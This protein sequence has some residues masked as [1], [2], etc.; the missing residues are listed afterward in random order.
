[1]L[2]GIAVSPG[3][4]VVALLRRFQR[5]EP[6]Y[7][8]AAAVSEEIARFDAACGAAAQEM[9]AVIARVT[10]QLG[11]DEAAIFHGHR[12]LLRDPA[13]VGKVKSSILHKKVDARSALHDLLDEYTSLFEKIEDEY[14]K[15]RMADIRDVV[16]H[17]D[18][19]SVDEKPK[20]LHGDEAII[21]VAR[22]RRRRRCWRF[23]VVGI[24]TEAG[25]STGRG[26]LARARHS[27]GVEA[28]GILKQVTGFAR[29]RRP[30]RFVFLKPDS[31]L[32]RRI[33]RSHGMH[34][35][36]ARRE[37]RS[38]GRHEGRHRH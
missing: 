33:A 23:N 13:L 19:S 2:K 36:Q 3:I 9:D 12:L 4:A 26:D 8:N 16:S 6:H 10:Q 21:L 34:L 24:I 32:R 15:E 37:S 1:M 18:A 22:N 20:T 31:E 14:L 25:G 29:S 17:H 30:R 11:D 38:S 7:L 27:V 35:G 5:G 28:A